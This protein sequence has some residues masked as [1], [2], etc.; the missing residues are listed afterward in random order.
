MYRISAAAPSDL[1]GWQAYVESRS[2]AEP[3]HHAGWHSILT[4]AFAVEPHYLIARQDSGEICGVLP[5]YFSRSL[6]TGPHLTSL[7][8][9]A[10][11]DNSD[12]AA[13]LAVEARRL[14]GSKGGKYFL[15]RGSDGYGLTAS[16]EHQAVMTIIDTTGGE[17]AIW[18]RIVN[19]RM[20][21]KTKSLMRTA[22]EQKLVIRLDEGFQ[23]VDGFYDLY[24]GHVH[25]LGTPVMTRRMM[26]AMV[27][28]K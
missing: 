15:L 10:L 5:T 21:E 18:G 25:R 3:M 12:V 16:A 23:S 28:H 6:V 13:A 19:K 1:A 27:Q 14:A 4:Q 8:G 7:D 20:R 24:C 2:D 26:H 17:D 9:G 22:H 11:T